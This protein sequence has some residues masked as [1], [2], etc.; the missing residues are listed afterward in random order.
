[1]QENHIL[2]Y[3]DFRYSNGP[4][5]ALNN[6]ARLFQRRAYGFH[7]AEAFIAMMMLGCGGFQID[8][9]LPGTGTY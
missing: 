6:K 5:E 9:P 3:I 7:S 4:L 2:A 1:V 8:A